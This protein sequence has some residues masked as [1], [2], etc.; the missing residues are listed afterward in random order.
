[1]S[2]YYLLLHNCLM[3]S[4]IYFYVVGIGLSMVLLTFKVSDCL[5]L[6]AKAEFLSKCE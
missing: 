2:H 4:S 6:L 5:I 1:M 3:F